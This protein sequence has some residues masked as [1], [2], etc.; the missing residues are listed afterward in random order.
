MSGPEPPNRYYS[1]ANLL[2]DVVIAIDFATKTREE[3]RVDPP[4][5]VL[6]FFDFCLD[7]SAVG[8]LLNLFKVHLERRGTP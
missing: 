6:A 2:K 4:E 7:G 8:L 5:R 1:Y 3:F